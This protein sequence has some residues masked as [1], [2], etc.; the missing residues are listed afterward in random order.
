MLPKIHKCS[1]GSSAVELLP[2]GN[3]FLLQVKV[4]TPLYYLI[5]LIIMTDSGRSVATQ[6][7]LLM[8]LWASLTLLVTV[9]KACLVSISDG[10]FS[11]FEKLFI[12]FFFSFFPSCYSLLPCIFSS[13]CFFSTI[14]SSFHFIRQSRSDSPHPERLSEPWPFRFNCSGQ[15]HVVWVQLQSTL[16]HTGRTTSGC[17]YVFFISSFFLSNILEFFLFYSIRLEKNLWLGIP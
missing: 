6:L 12:C 11:I 15:S 16:I 7:G 4:P 14:A 10:S 2:W 13:S 3:I 8:M 17:L 9:N 5:K 1:L